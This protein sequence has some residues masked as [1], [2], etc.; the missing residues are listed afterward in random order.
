MDTKSI[1]EKAIKSQGSLYRVAK[2]VG[3]SYNSALAWKHGKS[4][5]NG[6]NILRLL[7]L[8][9]KAVPGS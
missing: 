2:L 3:V 9:E 4:E 1:T 5:A 7:E 8:I 6:P